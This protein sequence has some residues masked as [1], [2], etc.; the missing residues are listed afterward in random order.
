[1]DA[2]RHQIG[3]CKEEEDVKKG[4]SDRR[5]S[6]PGYEWVECTMCSGEGGILSRWS[7]GADSRKIRCP[8]C[9][10]LGWVQT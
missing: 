6:E 5:P 2:R 9:F 1:M 3:L 8:R 10:R 4:L 7:A